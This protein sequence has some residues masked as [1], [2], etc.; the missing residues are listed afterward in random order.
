[1]NFCFVS[2]ER[3]APLLLNHYVNDIMQI[4]ALCHS[5]IVYLDSFE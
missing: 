1:M 2:N 3:N 4:S 5:V